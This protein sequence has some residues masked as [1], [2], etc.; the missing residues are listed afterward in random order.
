MN[1]TPRHTTS[2]NAMS[3]WDTQQVFHAVEEKSLPAA[4]CRTTTHNAQAI[5]S[6]PPRRLHT[7]TRHTCILL[8]PLYLAIR[9]ERFYGEAAV[10][11]SCA[12]CTQSQR[13]RVTRASRARSCQRASR[14][15][16]SRSSASVSGSACRQRA[17]RSA[18]ARVASAPAR[19]A[20]APR[21]AR[22]AAPRR[23][24]P[25]PSRQFTLPVERARAGTR[26]APPPCAQRKC[27]RAAAATPG[28]LPSRQVLPGRLKALL[29]RYQAA[30]WH[31]P[32]IFALTTSSF[33]NHTQIYPRTTRSNA[34]R[35][36]STR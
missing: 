28:Q 31:A 5:Q 12:A 20:R 17:R 29:W 9:I 26:M 10:R 11:Q 27:A 33:Q 7:H 1:V 36:P 30:I 19:A 34:A 25:A 3:S 21:A 14:M 23:R 32:M 15:P 2:Y 35:H 24:A 6:L 22:H 4:T 16:P 8:L 18:P 13:Q